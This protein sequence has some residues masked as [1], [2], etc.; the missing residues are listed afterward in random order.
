[1]ISPARHVDPGVSRNHGNVLTSV[2]ECSIQRRRKLIEDRRRRARRRAG[3]D[4]VVAGARR[5]IGYRNAGVQ[6]WSAPTARS[7]SSS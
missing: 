6:F 4:G 3:G 7:R 1:V 2:S 5:R